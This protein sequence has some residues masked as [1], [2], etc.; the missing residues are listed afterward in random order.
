V[1]TRLALAGI[2]AATATAAAAELDARLAGEK[3]GEDSDA[4]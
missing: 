1:P 3:F 2:V 4:A